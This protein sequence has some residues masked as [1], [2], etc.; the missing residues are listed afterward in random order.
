M[1]NNFKDWVN[2]RHFPSCRNERLRL[3]TACEINMNKW[4][5]VLFRQKKRSSSAFTDNWTDIERCRS[6]VS[7][8]SG[9]QRKWIPSLIF[10]SASARI[11]FF[12]L[13]LSSLFLDWKW[14]ERGDPSARVVSSRGLPWHSGNKKIFLLL[15]S[16]LLAVRN[17]SHCR[18]KK[19]RDIG[20]TRRFNDKIIN[21]RGAILKDVARV[22]HHCNSL[23]FTSKFEI[24]FRQFSRVPHQTTGRVTKNPHNKNLQKKSMRNSCARSEGN[25]GGIRK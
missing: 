13:S 10:P 23:V 19:A 15:P 2:W 7:S 18:R 17:R 9:W 11:C 22:F 16:P 1:V 8:V 21:H 14:R 5:S 25:G 3:S 12:F 20:Y 4:L 6:I 24:L